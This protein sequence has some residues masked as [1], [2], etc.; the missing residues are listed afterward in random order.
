M[1]I[2]QLNDETEVAENIKKY[3]ANIRKEPDEYTESRI[4][5]AHSI[6]GGL[7]FKIFKSTIIFIAKKDEVCMGAIRC[8]CTET[9]I[10]ID[11]ISAW[12]GAGIKLI[13]K[14]ISFAKEKK[15]IN[16]I[17]LNAAGEGKDENTKVIST[18]KLM[19]YYSR[20]GF[21]SNNKNI[22]EWITSGNLPE[23]KN[24]ISGQMTL[25]L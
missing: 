19:K 18:F 6:E 8:S 16:S 3:I 2:I 9:N 13:E 23:N 22:Q 1:E 15:T 10:H 5:V 25:N 14:V 20:F 21:I 7:C 12:K 4:S 11:H 17:T 24:F